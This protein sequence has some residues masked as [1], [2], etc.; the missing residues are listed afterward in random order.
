MNY[1]NFPNIDPYI[2]RFGD[3]GITWYSLS[4]VTGILLGWQY[5]N[6]LINNKYTKSKITT[7]QLDNFVTW[8]ILAVII[9]G[10]LGHVFLYEL[11]YYL[12]NPGEILKTYKGGMSFH[13]GLIGVILA[14]YIFSI[15]Y[16]LNFLKL[17]DFLAQTIP[18]GL[19]LGRIA[20][21]INAELYGYKTE[22]PWGVVFPGTDNAARHPTQIYEALLE[23]LVLFF[24]LYYFSIIKN[25]YNQKGFLSGIFLLFYGIFRSFV[26]LFKIPD[27]F[28]F[29]INSG[30]FYSLPMIF[31][32]TFLIIYSYGNR[33]RINK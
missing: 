28:I 25:Y 5:G 11:S 2:I 15:F 6:W 4:Y 33:N 12:S 18:F 10:R 14:T 22:M 13:G 16:K 27:D 32:G 31:C 8:V 29:G 19:F 26:E 3:L 23:G 21:F 20:N 24:I 7:E 9:G 1:I 30:Q 17:G